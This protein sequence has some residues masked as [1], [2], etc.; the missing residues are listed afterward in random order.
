MDHLAGKVPF[1]GV[2][3]KWSRTYPIDIKLLMTGEILAIKMRFL[4]PLRGYRVRGELRY[5]AWNNGAVQ[6]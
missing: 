6:D 1:N 3:L 2:V 5:E 4:V